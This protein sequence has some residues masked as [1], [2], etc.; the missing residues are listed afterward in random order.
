MLSPG[1][2]T[3][4][5]VYS[6]LSTALAFLRSGLAKVLPLALVRLKLLLNAGFIGRSEGGYGAKLHVAVLA[7]A[8]MRRFS[9]DPKFS[10]R[11]GRIPR[12]RLSLLLF[13]CEAQRP[14]L[15]PRGHGQELPE[16]FCVPLGIGL[17][18]SC[19]PCPEFTPSAPMF[20]ALKFQTAPLP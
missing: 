4:A 2:G 20:K 3:A 5:M 11:H 8:E 10:L 13:S 1:F 17:R 16:P 12:G 19:Y 9:H 7:D 14:F 15:E 18:A 6:N